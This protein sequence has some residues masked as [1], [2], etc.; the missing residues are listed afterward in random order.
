MQPSE[1]PIDGRVAEAIRNA[2]REDIGLGDVTTAA[3]VPPGL[4]G[5]GVFLA[6]ANG[7]LSGI[8]VAAA[9]FR[10]I[11]E[12]LAFETHV[13]NGMPLLRGM[14]IATVRGPVAPMLT[15]ERTALNFLQRM[16][17]IATRTALFVKLVEGTGVRILDTRKTA[18]GLRLFDKQAVRDGG[19]HNHR[20]GLDDMVLIKD[21]HIAAAGS[22][23][24]AVRRV[25]ERLS[26]GNPLRV[27]VEARTIAEV[28]EAAS[29]DGIDIIMLDNFPPGT[30]AQ[31][32]RMIRMRKP[33]VEIEASGNVTEQTVREIAQAGVTSIS[34]GALT[35]SVQAL[36]ISFDITLHRDAGDV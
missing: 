27:E 21:N 13:R 34:V 35:H 32:V 22:L 1:T 9:V 4:M 23:A 11:D 7:V 8:D 12:R 5:T 31:A 10:L 16:S 15:A 2:L 6:K 17:G 28:Y 36:D 24:E 30:I 18:P 3:T 25:R 14:T 20:F 33:S 26:P 19:G 29:C